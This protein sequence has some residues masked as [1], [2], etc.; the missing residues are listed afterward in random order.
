[1]GL[2][3]DDI[4]GQHQTVIKPLSGY[5]RDIEGLA[6]CTIL[7]DGS[8]ALILDGEAL[9]KRVQLAVSEAA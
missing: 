1:V 3:V 2:V 4:V 7:G 6:G 5:H 9:V 8:V